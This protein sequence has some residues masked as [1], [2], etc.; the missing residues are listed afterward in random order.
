MALL[1]V[2]GCGKKGPPRAPIRIV[3]T[4]PAEFTARR[5]GAEVHLQF[6]VPTLNTDGSSPADLSTVE[7]Y[8]ITVG[9]LQAGVNPLTDEEF[10]EVA[11]L[12]ATI[13]IRPPANPAGAEPSVPPLP[14]DPLLVLP[15]LGETVTVR[16]VLTQELL[17]PANLSDVDRRFVVDE[18]DEDDAKAPTVTGLRWVEPPLAL[19]FFEA[20]ARRT[21]VAIGR[22]ADGDFG[23][24]SSRLDGRLDDAP[25]PPGLPEVTY[26]IDAVTITW[27]AAPGATHTVQGPAIAQTLGT[28]APL[29]ST[30][31]IVSAEPTAYNVYS[32]T[33]RIAEPIDSDVVIPMLVNPL[34]L[35]VLEWTDTSVEFGVERCYVVRAIATMD[36][37]P[38]ESEPSQ[39]ACVE[40][41]DTFPPAPPRNLVAVGSVGAVS[42]IWQPSPDSDLAGY[43]VLRGESPGDT[44]QPLMTELLPET[45]YQDTTGT[46]GVVYVYAVVAVDAAVSPN[47][48][49]PSNRVT[50]SPQ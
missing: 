10:V 27:L 45:T 3:P 41:H 16:E 15:V 23:N 12:L 34:P 20:P 8:A 38:I 29:E 32:Y 47:V 4:A 50:E 33:P 14:D 43:L 6:D 5:L 39:P 22:T 2:V 30:P 46:A 17:T 24:M 7:V 28:P 26:V 31:A 48:S 42:L 35:D 18:D 1:P 25:K 9:P 13:D 37:E 19:P 44:L 40:F 21:Y 36:G 49:E 11:T